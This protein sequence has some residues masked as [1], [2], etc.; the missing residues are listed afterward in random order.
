[1][2]GRSVQRR[3]TS[4]GITVIHV[5]LSCGGVPWPLGGRALQ[6]SA[7]GLTRAPPPLRVEETAE[8]SVPPFHL[9][10]VVLV[11]AHD[12]GGAKMVRLMGE[13]R[14]KGG[15]RQGG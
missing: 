4:R 8:P 14:D 1:M 2:G 12:G 9:Y 7:T 10:S 5:P 15:A 6:R 3:Q 11:P 13:G